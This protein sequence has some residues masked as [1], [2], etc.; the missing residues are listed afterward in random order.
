MVRET[1][2]LHLEGMGIA[3][4][5]VGHFLTA[6]FLA[7]HCASVHLIP[8]ILI[9]TYAWECNSIQSLALKFRNLSNNKAC[10]GL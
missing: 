9:G 7:L 1:R 2:D 4:M 5:M 3:F 10:P 8:L 6:V